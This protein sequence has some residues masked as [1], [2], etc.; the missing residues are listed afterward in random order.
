MVIS[1][2]SKSLKNHRNLPQKSINKIP[3]KS[4][5]AG[6]HT[7]R[8][9]H[10]TKPP[11]AHMLPNRTFAAPWK[12]LEALQW[13]EVSDPNPP[14]PMGPEWGPMTAMGPLK[15][16][17][18]PVLETSPKLSRLLNVHFM[19]ADSQHTWWHIFKPVLTRDAK[20]IRYRHEM[21]VLARV[22]YLVSKIIPSRFVPRPLPP[23]SF[24]HTT[25]FEHTCKLM[26]SAMRS[27]PL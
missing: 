21:G 9:P 1:P 4:L 26:P 27:K 25:T 7:A 15:A 2:A 13:I 14:G 12:L 3:L 20:L 24:T 18:P 8:K 11:C 17:A 16:H 10:A 5:G 22:S 23:F 19:S 6:H